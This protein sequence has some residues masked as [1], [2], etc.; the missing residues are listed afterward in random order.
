MH[1][2]LLL[3]L[4]VQPR[5]ACYFLIGDEM[6][7]SRKPD[8]NPIKS[9]DM[10]PRQIRLRRLIYQ[11]SYTGMKETDL[12]L[13]HFASEHLARMTDAQ[14]DDFEALLDAGDDRIYAWVMGNAPVPADHDNDVFRL[15]KEFK[16]VK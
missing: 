9:G 1:Q 10:T 13:G 4:A 2:N 16:K 6:E 7:Q 8:P 15:I 3:S 14:L 12:L 11:S 5:K